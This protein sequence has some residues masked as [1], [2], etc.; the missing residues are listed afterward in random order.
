MKGT[1]GISIQEAWLVGFL[2]NSDGKESACNAG[3]PDSIPRLGRSPGERIG[4][5]LQYSWA[6]L[7]A[8]AVKNSPQ[9]GRP[10]FNP[11]ITK[12]PW[13]RAW[14]PT[15]VFLLENPHGQRSLD[16]YTPWGCKESD[17]TE[18]QH[19]AQLGSQSSALDLALSRKRDESHLSRVGKK[20]RQ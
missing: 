14:Q 16:G 11:W 20:T 10:G 19:T 12:I 3:D 2:G 5:P 15:P 1:A 8:Q 4:Y 9:C 6:S 7:V 13:R 18:W 17:T